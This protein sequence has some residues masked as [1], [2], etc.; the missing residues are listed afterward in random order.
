MPHWKAHSIAAFLQVRRSVL[1]NVFDLAVAMM[2][3]HE[4]SNESRAVLFN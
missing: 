2:S 3:F 4:L 1:D